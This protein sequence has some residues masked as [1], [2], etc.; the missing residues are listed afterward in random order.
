MFGA[1]RDNDEFAG[2][3]DHIACAQSHLHPPRDDEEQFILGLMMMPVELA[4]ELDQLDLKI[5]DVARDARIPVIVEG[6]EGFGKIDL[7][8]H[9]HSPGAVALI[10]S[11]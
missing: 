5:I 3:D 2:L 10:A 4:S 6:C 8:D 9:G 1:V 7:V 11:A